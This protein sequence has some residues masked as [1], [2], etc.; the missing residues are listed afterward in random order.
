[1]IEIPAHAVKQT[2]VAFVRHWLRLL[3]AGRWEEACGMIDEPN[4]YAITWTPE[5]IQQVV[6]DSFGPGCRFRSRHP[7]GIRWS[8]PDEL[9][10][11]GH[12]E[13][14]PQDDGSG[15]A[16]DHDIPLNGEWSDLTAQFE[17]HHRPQGYAVVL[18]DLHVL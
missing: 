18:H 12:P 14:Y 4:C 8:D 17:F 13:I 9:G 2:L 1:M 7:E 6:E 5:R 11:G 10:D 3:A 16:F 15:Y